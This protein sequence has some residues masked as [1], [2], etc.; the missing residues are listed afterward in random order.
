MFGFVKGGKAARQAPRMDIGTL[1]KVDISSAFERTNASAGSRWRQNEEW[2]RAKTQNCYSYEIDSTDS[3]DSSDFITYCIFWICFR[4]SSSFVFRRLFLGSAVGR[5]W[6]VRCLLAV[7]FH[8]SFYT[9]Y[10]HSQCIRK[11][12][13]VIRTMRKH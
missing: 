4:L 1:S 6:S 8:V 11:Q 12:S 7:G 9:G 3:Y 13:K 2:E 10:G 5:R